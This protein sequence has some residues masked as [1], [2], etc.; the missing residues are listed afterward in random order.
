M[1]RMT[2]GEIIETLERYP[3][4]WRVTIGA[5]LLYWDG[6][7]S[8]RGIYTE[9]ACGYTTRES[10]RPVAEVLRD[11]R[12]LV[13]GRTFTGYKGGEYSYGPHQE[14]HVAN[15]GDV[16]DS[17]IGSV[18]SPH[19]GWVTLRIVQHEAQP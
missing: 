19:E 10:P 7:H 9:P 4:T 6:V 16:G 11:L 15:H 17:Y 13:S 5:P 8:Y 14:L 18:T 1:T 12:D 2:I 3:A